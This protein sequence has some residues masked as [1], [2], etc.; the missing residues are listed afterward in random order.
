MTHALLVAQA[1]LTFTVAGGG[2][3]RFG[4]PLPEAALARGLALEGSA[5]AVLQW[6]PLH[7][8]ADPRTQ[9]RWCEIVVAGPGLEHDGKRTLRLRSGGGPASH[10]AGGPVCTRRVEVEQASATRT[11]TTSWEYV[12]GVV[13][14]RV[15][16]EVVAG[17]LV[18]GDER[19]AVGEAATDEGAAVMARTLRVSI[20]PQEWARAGVIPKPTRLGAPWRDHL[21]AAGKQLQSLPG[22]RG[23]GDFAREGGVVTNLE[24]DTTL[25]FARL[26]LA[27]ADPTLLARAAQSARHLVDHD[28]EPDSG[29][30]F[31][32]GQDHRQSPPEPGHAWL[33]GLL[34]AGCLF[35]EDDWITAAGSMARGLARRP[36][37]PPQYAAH[38]RARDLGWPLLEMEAWLR[39]RPD[40]AVARAA[41]D[42]AR[43]LIARFDARAGVVRFGEGERRDGAYEDRAWLTGGILVPALRAYAERTRDARARAIVRASEER[44]LALLRRGQRGIPIR[45]YVDRDGLGSELRLSGTAEGFLVLEGL[46]PVGLGRILARSQVAASLE[47][48]PRPDDPDVAT[49]FSIAA[50]CQWVLR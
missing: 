21:R 28:L 4:F 14:R 7:S 34:L 15:R 35:A 37:T 5:D 10:D 1:L 32:H 9:R 50:R 2:P 42:V 11:T 6:R 39:F 33:Q 48:V 44:L 19:L 46:D 3:V 45:Y 40:P 8:A 24:F 22:V 31:A 23:A 18:L 20:A 49:Q 12:G 29:L 27:C 25:G 13:D 17:E 36:R 30:P 26:G 16:T 47:G 38:D 43:E 41:D